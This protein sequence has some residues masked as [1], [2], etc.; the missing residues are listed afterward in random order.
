MHQQS[1]HRAQREDFVE[2]TA[3]AGGVVGNHIRDAAVQQRSH[4]GGVV[5]GPGVN[6]NVSQPRSLHQV[7]SDVFRLDHQEV[8]VEL[9]EIANRGGSDES[10]RE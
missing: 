10:H 5:H 7:L 8:D 3:Q 9:T 4:P 2:L 1:L 6:L